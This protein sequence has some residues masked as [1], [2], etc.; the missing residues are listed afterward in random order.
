[1]VDYYLTSQEATASQSHCQAI[2]VQGSYLQDRVF[3]NSGVCDETSFDQFSGGSNC[4]LTELHFSKEE[5]VF[6]FSL[7]NFDFA[8]EQGG[9]FTKCLD[10]VSK[11]L[12]SLFFLNEHGSIYLPIYLSS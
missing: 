5:L 8:G 2:C 1:M 6:F 4:H 7:R 3:Y 10:V 12:G 9:E 11:I